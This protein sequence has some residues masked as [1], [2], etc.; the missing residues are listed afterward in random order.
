MTHQVEFSAR[1]N[2]MLVSNKVNDIVLEKL[3]VL[4]VNDLADFLGLGAYE[5][6][7]GDFPTLLGLRNGTPEDSIVTKMDVRQN[8]LCPV[9]HNPLC[10]AR[11]QNDDRPRSDTEG[12]GQGLQ[13][14]RI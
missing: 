4:N 7:L 5:K 2:E 3:D 10:L 12:Y 8:E 14:H 11:M 6:D 13:K 9:G 1:L